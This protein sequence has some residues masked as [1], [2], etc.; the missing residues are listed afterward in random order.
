[1]NLLLS[2]AS[3]TLGIALLQRLLTGNPL[4]HATCVVRR[5]QSHA[6][7][8][9]ALA[10]ELHARVAPIV[11]DLTDAAAVEAAATSMQRVGPMVGVHLAADVSWDKT[12]A[13]MLATNVQGTQNFCRL[14]LQASSAARLIY[15]STAYTQ[16][17]DWT[18][19]N[20]YEESKALAERTL[21]QQFGAALPISTFSCSLVVGDSSSGAISRFHGLYP[22]IRFIAT[23]SPPFLVGNKH[24]LLDIVPLDWVVTELAH[25]IAH[26]SSSDTRRDV[27]AAAGAQ[28]L[29]YETVVRLIE[30]RVVLACME[31]DLPPP[32]PVPILRERQWHFLK[33]SLATWQPPGI[34][35]GD[36]RYFE[37]LLQVYG[38][39]ATSDRVRAPLNVTTP[40]PDPLSFLPKAIDYWLATRGRNLRSRHV[41]EV[42]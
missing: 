36:F 12:C 32:Q 28:R 25:H 5:E 23:F 4:L 39:Y 13:Q 3:G 8:L 21:R 18:Y 1:V 27:V 2:G 19:R 7:L 17:E 20:G 10:P 29:S 35:P 30:Q 42:A 31:R 38:C 14:L 33:R 34:A 41:E 37:R 11:L 6:A 22:L 40:L 26:C 9:A 24:G 15:V 16:T